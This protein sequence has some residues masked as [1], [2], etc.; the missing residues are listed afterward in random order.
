MRGGKAYT[1]EQK[2]REFK[3]ILQKSK[4]MHKSSSTKRIEPKKLIQC[5]ANNLNNIPS[6]KYGVS[7]NFVEENIQQDEKLRRI[8][9]FYRLVKV[10]KYTER[11]KCNDIRKDDKKREKLRKPL[12][13]G[14]KVFVLAER[15]KK[16]HA[17][18][19][20]IRV[21]LRTNHFLTEMRHILLEELLLFT[22]FISGFQKQLAVK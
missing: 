1:A 20:F 6:Q 15:L 12:L 11:Y 21:Q 22:I 3:K 2:I 5:A 18:G 14:E 19:V 9:D 4:R 13:I 8:F 10:Q 16:K 7:P 17:P